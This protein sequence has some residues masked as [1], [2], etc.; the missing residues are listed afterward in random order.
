[1]HK[2]LNLGN[3]LAALEKPSKRRRIPSPYDT[4]HTTRYDSYFKGQPHI[5]FLGINANHNPRD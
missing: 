5:I 4:S 1:M 2:V 3:K